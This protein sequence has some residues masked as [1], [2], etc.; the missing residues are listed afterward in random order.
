[1]N[2]KKGAVEIFLDMGAG[3]AG[4]GLHITG[5]ATVQDL[6]DAWQPLCD[7][8]TIFK[9][10]A[11]GNYASCKGCQQNCCATAYVIPDLVSFRKIAALKGMDYVEFIARYFQP[12]KQSAGLLRML[13]DPCVFLNDSIC[14]IYPVRSLICRF[15][16]CTPLL[17]DTEQLIY[18]IA[19]TGATATQVF[20]RKNGL[21][22]EGSGAA[23]SFDQLFIN[24][25]EEYR[26]HPAIDLFLHAEDYDQIPL[27]LF[28]P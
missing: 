15:Y 16:I 6:L 24:L 7:D 20:A 11:A 14:S 3:R 1:M 5:E 26:H 9:S 2:A 17:G 4:L 23:S 28:L 18:E 27:S 13:P 8:H 25:L 21:L 19:W 22:P 10:Y 12:E